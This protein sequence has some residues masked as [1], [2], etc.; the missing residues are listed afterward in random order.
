MRSG[1]AGHTDQP[2]A[3]PAS[4]SQHRLTRFAILGLFAG[5][6]CLAWPERSAAHALLVECLIRGERVEVKAVFD[7]GTR[8]HGAKVRVLDE[9]GGEL[10]S[11]TTDENGTW[12]FAVPSPGRYR[13]LVDAGAGHRAETTMTIGSLLPSHGRVSS[14]PS[15]EEFT[16]F[17]GV[18][19]VIGVSLIFGFCLVL[20]LLNRSRRSGG[21]ANEQSPSAS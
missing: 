9:R 21:S 5:T 1:C 20:W 13:V 3:C 10:A 14:G 18:Q 8:P 2:W 12:H 4:Y 17:K 7:D 16:R 19:I 6:I 15:E 11:G